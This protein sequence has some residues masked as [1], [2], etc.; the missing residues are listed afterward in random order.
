M[1]NFASFLYYICKIFSIICNSK[2]YNVFNYCP[3][4]VIFFSFRKKKIQF[5]QKIDILPQLFI[6]NIINQSLK[7]SYTS[8]LF[9]LA[10]KT[11]HT[12]KEKKKARQ[13]WKIVL[14]TYAGLCW[15]CLCLM[16]GCIISVICC[17]EHNEEKAETVVT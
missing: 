1:L 4:M 17:T 11:S 8:C 12:Q 6:N 5:T 10:I 15:F 16:G 13:Y 9:V 7:S 2:H 14:S 3:G